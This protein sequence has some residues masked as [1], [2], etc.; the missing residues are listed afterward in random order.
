[1]S[2]TAKVSEFKGRSDEEEVGG[3]MNFSV[4]APLSEALSMSVAKLLL[5][6]VFN[7]PQMMMMLI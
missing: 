4:N 7:L 3:K 6:Y 2:L 1:M 5:P